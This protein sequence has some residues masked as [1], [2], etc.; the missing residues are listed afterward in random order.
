MGIAVR[1]YINT[2]YEPPWRGDSKKKSVG[3]GSGFDL[4]TFENSN[5]QTVFIVGSSN[6]KFEL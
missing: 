3:F 2:L 6:L 5:L 4:D 1:Y